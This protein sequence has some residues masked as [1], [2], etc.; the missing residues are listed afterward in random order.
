M[1]RGASLPEPT[2][3]DAVELFVE[4]HAS[5]ADLLSLKDDTEA[6]RTVTLWGRAALY[7]SG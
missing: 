6:V 5:V 2:L 1:L 4:G 7:S 3:A